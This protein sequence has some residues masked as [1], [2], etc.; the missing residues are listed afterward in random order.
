MIVVEP[1]LRGI[2]E[3]LIARWDTRRID[4]VLCFV[5]RKV[6]NLV[7]RIGNRSRQSKTVL[8]ANRKSSPPA[9]QESIFL[10]LKVG[11]STGTVLARR[12]DDRKHE[13]AG[14]E[15]TCPTQVG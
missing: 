7:P 11:Q 15:L 2:G 5:A 13:V 12:C 14:D 3:D 6:W 1:E 9:C 8:L 10:M 4:R